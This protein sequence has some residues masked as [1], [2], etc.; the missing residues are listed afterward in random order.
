MK[1]AGII[2]EYNPFHAGHKRQIDILKKSG[3]DCIVCVMSG[4]Y[5]QRGEAAVY[6]KYT[7]AKSAILCGADLVLE[8]PFPY[9][10][11]SAEG[12]ALSGVHILNSLGKIDSISFGSETGDTDTLWRIAKII[13][14]KE[15][16]DEYYK[17]SRTEGSAFAFFN[18]LKDKGF[19]ESILSND[20]LAVNYL[21]ALIRTDSKLTPFVIQRLGTAYNSEENTDDKLPSATALRSM[22]CRNGLESL[23]KE[24]IPSQAQNV[25]EENGKTVCLKDNTSIV[26]FFRLMSAEDIRQRA[27]RISL[28]TQIAEDGCG[29]VERLCKAAMVSNNSPDD[30]LN[31]AKSTMFTDSR[32]NRVILFSL[33]GVSD[34]LANTFPQ[35]TMLLGAN[36]IGCKFLSSIRKSSEIQIVTKPADIPLCPSK[37]VNEIADSFYT[38]LMCFGEQGNIFLKKHPFIR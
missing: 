30:L 35:Y 13:T 10:S 36:S 25:Y 18:I 21:K 27:S 8:L 32:L 20:I 24:C 16:E 4:N 31:K 28:G 29:I 22:I 3:F 14:S 2:C 23:P 34:E 7:R 11:L 6:D 37:H 38:S 33:F 26:S 15:F 5:T 17:R 9:C 1:T 12:F 19:D